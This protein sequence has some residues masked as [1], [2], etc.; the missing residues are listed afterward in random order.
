MRTAMLLHDIG[1]PMTVSTDVN[2]RSHFYNHPKLSAAMANT[3]L[4][5]LKYPTA[6]INTV[7]ILIEYH[8]DRLTPYSP[9]VKSYL[10]KLG[11][12]NMRMLLSIQRADIL[13]QSLYERE[14]KISTLDAVCAEFER[15]INSDECY[16]L[17]TLAINGKDI[18]HL[19]VSSGENIG[20]VLDKCLDKVISGELSNNH[21]ELIS[22]AKNM[23]K[24]LEGMR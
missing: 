1:K 4:R 20:K 8:D 17:S 7:L 21:D 6:F 11:E 10:R 9:C 13:A 3:I 18:I 19:G 12:E 23:I 5:R 14:D 16:S 15:V 24:S 22:F 2:G